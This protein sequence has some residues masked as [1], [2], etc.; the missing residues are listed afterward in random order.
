MW[1]AIAGVV[2]LIT[3]ILAWR[4]NPKGQ[5]YKELDEIYR[6]LEE[7]YKKRDEA[8]VNHDTDTLTVV[9]DAIIRLCVRKNILL[10]RL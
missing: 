2:G 5:I 9:T 10:S 1:T 3:T 8:L 6:Q 4:F 7:L